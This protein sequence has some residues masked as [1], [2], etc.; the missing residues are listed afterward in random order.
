MYSAETEFNRNLDTLMWLTDSLPALTELGVKGESDHPI[1]LAMEQGLGIEGLKDWLSNAADA[2][3]TLLKRLKD[4]FMELMDSVWGLFTRNSRRQAKQE[5]EMETREEGDGT[6]VATGPDE[7]IDIEEVA[8]QL[9]QMREEMEELKATQKSHVELIEDLIAHMHVSMDSMRRSP[10]PETYAKAMELS[11]NRIRRH[12][13]DE[14]LKRIKPYRVM[15]H[16]DGLVTEYYIRFAYGRKYKVALITRRGDYIV[17]YRERWA[18]RK[19]DP[20]LPKVKHYS[21]KTLLA[22][23]QCNREIARYLRAAERLK[24]GEETKRDI[25]RLTR[26]VDELVRKF[27]RVAGDDENLD[28][29]TRAAYTNTINEIT[30]QISALAQRSAATVDGDQKAIAEILDALDKLQDVY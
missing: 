30:K 6:H 14:V 21:T 24:L 2:I 23:K 27:K 19:M 1:V 8:E 16:S 28:E 22:L 13:P 9:K 4:W 15:K 12:I 10:D 20:A 5:K 17:D 26:Q 7:T 11:S 25:E 18:N 3:V 29:E